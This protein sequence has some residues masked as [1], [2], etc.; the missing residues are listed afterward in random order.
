MTQNQKSNLTQLPVALLVCSTLGLSACAGAAKK[1]KE[2]GLA[3]AVVGGV[4]GAATGGKKGAAIGAATGA[5][6]GAAIG[7]Y[8][9]RRARELDKVVETKKTNDGLMVTL[10]N[11]VLFDFDRASLKDQAQVTLKEL[12][13]ILAKYP[14]D[15]LRIT[16]FTDNIGTEAYNQ[17]LSEERA[18]AVRGFLSEN[19][20]AADRM[21]AVGV[22]ETRAKGDT[23]EARA[24]DRKVEIYIDV[25]EPRKG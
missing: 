18:A 16:G 7:N 21:N 11:D 14:G 15:K 5:A 24:K 13:D 6:A 25:Q 23:D 19:G 8:L 20:V 22:G 2:G 1:T 4:V 17:D 9:D 12:A 10:K 3:G